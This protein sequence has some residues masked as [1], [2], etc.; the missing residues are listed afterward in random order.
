MK[1]H[2]YETVKQILERGP[3]PL[4]SA[5][6]ANQSNVPRFVLDVIGRG[7][8]ANMDQL[9]QYV[10]CTLFWSS[11]SAEERE[12]LWQQVLDQAALLQREGFLFFFA[13]FSF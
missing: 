1:K 4:V 5:I 10:S 11:A 7:I 12:R 8:V 13:F 3:N 2:E 9:K 6:G